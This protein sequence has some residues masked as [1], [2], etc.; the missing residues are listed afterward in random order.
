MRIR[1]VLFDADG[2]I[3]VPTVDWRATLRTFLR[4]DQSAEEFV[5]DLMTSER[6]SLTGKGDFREATAEVLRR[7]EVSTP[8]AE[9]LA[10]WE[11]FAAV[12][13]AIDV[14]QELR[15]AGIPCHL[16]TNQQAY[17]REIMNDRRNYGQWFDRSFYSCDLGVA[18]P[19]PAYFKAI[20]TAI[21]L[22]PSSVLFVDDTAPN[23]DGARE[24]GLYAEQFDLS[25]GVPVLRGLLHGY[26]L[27]VATDDPEQRQ[28]G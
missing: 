15:A 28:Q 2:V 23:I 19:D 26:G 14:V 27:P 5:L 4:P 7:W 16:A 13:E 10:L 24:A 21:D 8:V 18:K 11:Q 9:V 12:P 20:V 17:R 22:P 25:S 3:Q 6:P 1:A